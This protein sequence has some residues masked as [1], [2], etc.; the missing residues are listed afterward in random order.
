MVISSWNLTGSPGARAN[1]AT[2]I[3]RRIT[4]PDRRGANLSA[5]LPTPFVPCAFT[6]NAAPGKA[7]DNGAGDPALSNMSGRDG[8]VDR[9]RLIS[10]RKY[11]FHRSRLYS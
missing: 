8:E 7:L 2:I 6:E 10:I 4:S 11:Y 9:A 5:Q 3:N 1:N